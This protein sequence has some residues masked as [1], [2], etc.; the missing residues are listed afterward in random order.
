MAKK[1]IVS[2]VGDQTIPNILF[3]KEKAEADF[4]FFITTAQME[5][6]NVT[7]NIIKSS[8][9]D[10]AQTKRIQVLED[11]IKDIDDNLSQQLEFDDEDELM[12]N[13]TGGT[14]IM[15]LA[16]Y[17]FF[18]RNGAGEIFYI[19]IGK[20]EIRQIFPLRKNRLSMITNRVNLKEY[21]SAYG[22][23]VRQSSFNSKNHLLK[24]EEQTTSLF[25]MFLSDKRNELFNAAEKI[26]SAKLRGKVIRRNQV[27]YEQYFDIAKIFNEAGVKWKEDGVISG[28]ETKYLT[29]EW[30]E[31]Y[32]YPRIKKWLNKSEEEIGLGLQLIKGDTPNEFDIMFTHNNSLYVIECKTDVADNSEGKISYLFTNTLYK[33]ATLKK[34]FGLWVNYY[35]FALND[36]SKLSEDQKNRAKQLDIKLVGLELLSDEN[37]FEAFIKQS[38]HAPQPL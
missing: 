35:L 3:I 29:G 27:D 22:V 33:A 21:L 8:T 1:I 7:D 36:F 18:T 6:K 12:I 15:S 25:N 34:E 17:N 4:Y 11:S 5:N 2:I 37:K 38:L 24:Q 16:A 26:R 10:P 19:P 20:N 31:E 23:S 30:L 14:K 32:V 28:A 9:L 13:I